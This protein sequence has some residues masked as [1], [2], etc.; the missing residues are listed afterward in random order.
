MAYCPHK[1]TKQH[2]TRETSMVSQWCHTKPALDT[3]DKYGQSVFSHK[4]SSGHIRQGLVGQWSQTKP[5]LDTSDRYG[6]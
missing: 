2:W 6:W 4:A 3:S 1:E 5:S